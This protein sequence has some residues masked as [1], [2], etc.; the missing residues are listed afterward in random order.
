MLDLPLLS[1][2]PEGGLAGSVT[3]TVWV[4][5][6]VVVFFH[7][8]FGWVLSG[9]VV[10]GYLV[11]LLLAK[12]AAAFVVV[13]EGIATYWMVWFY[14]E[15]LSEKFRFSNFF[16]RDRFFALVLCSILVRILS[17]GFILPAFGEWVNQTFQ[18]QF[19]YRNNLHSFG[20]II[21]SLIAN[22]FWKTG[23]RQGMIPLVVTIAITLL[24]VRYLLM[25]LTNFNISSLSYAYEDLAV[26]ILSSPKA[27]IILVVTAFLA[28][29]MNLLYGWD[30][31][32]ILVPSLLALQWYQPSKILATFAEAA[33]IIV[34]AHGVLQLPIFRGVTIEGG[35]KLLL[36]FNISYFY[37]FVLAYV[38]LW[39]WPE[40]KITDVYGFGYLLSTLI[41][42]KMYEKGIYAR[43]TRAILQVSLSAAFGATLI[44][45]AISWLPDPWLGSVTNANAKTALPPTEV[46]NETLIALMRREKLALQRSRLQTEIVTPTGF[47]LD[48]FRAG[49]LQLAEY[50]RERQP[51][52]L[53]EASQ[54]L[55]DVGF[56]L[57][58]SENRYLLVQGKEPRRFWGIY[59]VDLEA[60]TDL[61][62]EVPAPLDEKG[63]LEAGTWLFKLMGGQSLAIA[64]SLRRANQDGSIDVLVAPNSTY[65]VFHQ[66][67]ATRQT[68]QVRGYT[69][70]SARLAS[71]ERRRTEQLEP[72]PANST[73][74]VKGRVPND[75]NLAKLKDA[76]GDFEVHW[77]ELPLKNLQ[78]ETSYGAYAELILRKDEMRRLLSRALSKEKDQ[79]AAPVA[80][81][82]EGSLQDWL[83]ADSSRI[84]SSGSNLYR[85]PALEDLLFF[86]DEIITPLLRATARHYGVDGWSAAGE[87]ELRLIEDAASTM[88]YQL[89]RYRHSGNGREYL[90]LSEA[91][92]PLENRRYWGSY[93]FRTG[94]SQPYVIHAPRPV[95]EVNSLEMAVALFESLRGQALLIAGA[96]PNANQDF[97]AD[98]LRFANKVNLFNTVHQALLREAGNQ[99]L[100]VVQSRATA[101]RRDLPQPATDIVISTLSGAQHEM[102]LSPLG[103]GLIDTLKSYGMSYSLADGSPAQ[104]GYEAGS[105]PQAF[106]LNATQN[107]ELAVFWAVPLARASFLQQ[108][109][110]TPQQAQTD[111]LGLQTQTLDISAFLA[112]YGQIFGPMPESLRHALMPYFTNPDIVLLHA[113]LRQHPDLQFERWVDLNSRQGFLVVRDSRQRL[114]A[115]A[116]LSARDGSKTVVFHPTQASSAIASFIDGRAAWLL[117]AEQP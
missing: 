82:I 77:G 18:L 110:P 12:P 103:R 98:L 8:R 93:I 84:A 41:A 97:S 35:R 112:G 45:F 116:N 61:A 76:M 50:R 20:L 85:K 60:D 49:L 78:R 47:E 109:T 87:D 34:L 64:G 48:R 23:L 63:T 1:I 96:T 57:A 4:G 32:G 75:L 36:F 104:A 81:R 62:I 74:W 79:A 107:K 9:L 43:M 39:L 7:L 6:A 108:T 68:L 42:V 56:H 65:Q 89:Q 30:F 67:F 66:V 3:T 114:L 28:S 26:S 83:L 59:V 70:Q 29:R 2:F 25:T 15:Y 99:P 11:P 91:A 53:A 27:Y 14:S 33:I 17:D 71:G 72:T 101:E 51:E 88:G 95:L 24:I 44:G 19:D 113:A 52:R 73:L 94:P 22:N 21:V 117:G 37:K 100:M 13:G 92:I 86:D 55:A 38:L 115:L 31:S 69:S 58:L 40:Q 105:V 106:Y 16:G 46:R 111:A 80:R 90:V 5:I 102:Q 10:P 54:L